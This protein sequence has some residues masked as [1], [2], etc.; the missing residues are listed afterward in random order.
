MRLVNRAAC[1]VASLLLAFPASGQQVPV[2]PEKDDEIVVTGRQL[3]E[4][5][6]DFVGA[7]T[8][9]RHV[10]SNIPRFEEAVC[11]IVLGL[12]PEQNEAVAAR[13]RVVATAA[14]LPVSS[15]G[16]VANVLLAV[17][18]D[19]QA[20]IQTVASRFGAAAFGDMT[21]LQIRRLAR[22][23]GPSAAWQVTG[24]RKADGSPA[25]FGLNRST[26]A[27]SRLRPAGRWAFEGSNL[28]VE[29]KALEGLTVTQLADYA[30]MRL[31]ARTDP[32]RVA[33]K[34]PTILNVLEAP[35]GSAIPITLTDWDLGFLRG[36]YSSPEN[37]FASPQRSAIAKDMREELGR[38]RSATE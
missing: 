18:A 27:S 9:T 34:A 35:M 8:H 36:L 13:L 7:L 20:F 29:R 19:K 3:E 33:G 11:P 17:T 14:G 38:R 26:E 16:C 23:A 22:S 32:A 6:R 25:M 12:A 30:A 21:S 37:Q 4:Q 2:P 15:P 31:F 5:V 24:Q 28:V 1:A 10:D